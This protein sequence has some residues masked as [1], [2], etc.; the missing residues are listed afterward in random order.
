MKIPPILSSKTI[1]RLTQEEVL[2]TE[3]HWRQW[4]DGGGGKRERVQFSFREEKR[5]SQLI[6][7][8]TFKVRGGVYVSKTVFFRL[9]WKKIVCACGSEIEYDFFAF[10]LIVKL[11]ANSIVKNM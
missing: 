3:S 11:Q 8:E 7:T 1:S 9:K 4:T 6:R 2:R 10:E 5:G